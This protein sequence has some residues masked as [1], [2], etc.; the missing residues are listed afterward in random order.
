MKLIREL[1]KRWCRIFDFGEHT[2]NET[3]M[4]S[5]MARGSFTALSGINR[6]PN[7]KRSVI[8]MVIDTG[9]LGAIHVVIGDLE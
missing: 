2:N 8:D 3:K 1:Y 4:L 7:A 9:L 5:T 6:D